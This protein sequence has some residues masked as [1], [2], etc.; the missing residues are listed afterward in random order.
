MWLTSLD[1]VLKNIPIHKMELFTNIPIE[2]SIL[3]DRS[4]IGRMALPLQLG[5]EIQPRE[6][7]TDQTIVSASLIYLTGILYI[8]S[9]SC[10]LLIAS[11]NC[12]VFSIVIEIHKHP[13]SNSSILFFIS[14][15]VS[16]LPFKD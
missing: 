8:L 4:P 7:Y 12:S 15:V 13:S 3:L 2:N 6:S 10:T 11:I 14:F 5:T 16:I 1:F 9:H